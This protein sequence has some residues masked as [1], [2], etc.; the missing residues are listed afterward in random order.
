[1]AAT[2]VTSGVL[3]SLK[4]FHKLADLA[5][6]KAAEIAADAANAERHI[7]ALGNALTADEKAAYG[8]WLAAR[9]TAAAAV[10]SV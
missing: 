4:D 8:V 9:E 7:A 2:T 6:A 1:M 5:K 3:S 10:K